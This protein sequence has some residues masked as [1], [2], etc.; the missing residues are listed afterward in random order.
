[1]AGDAGLGMRVSL[2]LRAGRCGRAREPVVGIRPRG[3]LIRIEAG[4]A[5]PVSEQHQLMAAALTYRSEMLGVPGQIQ[6][7]LERLAGPVP[8]RD[9]SHGQHRAIYAA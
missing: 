4:P 5:D 2:R 9:G 8:A 6:R 1:M 7:D 3:R